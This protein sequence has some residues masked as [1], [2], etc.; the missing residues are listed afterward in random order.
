MIDFVD[1]M[2]EQLVTDRMG[3][4]ATVSFE[5]PD[6]HW[7]TTAR[8]ADKD[9]LNVYLAD[10]RENR[11]LRT[12]ERVRTAVDGVVTDEPAPRRV[13]CHYLASAWS[14]A[15]PGPTGSPARFEHALLHRF[16]S[17]LAN[18]DPF[19]ASQIYGSTPFQPSFPAVLVDAA[20][21]VTLLPVEG[22][23][24]LAELWGTMGDG[25]PV[26]PVVYFVVTVPLTLD[27]LPAGPIVTTR[28]ARFRFQ[29]D[30][31]PGEVL[32]E[33][34]GAVLDRSL[35]ASPGDP[36]PPVPG[37]WV[38]LLD[39]GGRRVQLTQAGASGRFT[40]SNLPAGSYQLRASV[41]SAVVPK[42]LPISIPAAD[43]HYDLVF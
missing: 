12:N 26:K 31:A 33:I 41:P 18:T 38:D 16:A 40:F 3:A 34:G 5:A 8:P 37:T 23:V 28:E 22:F 21:P 10:L 1:L 30:P 14:R 2:L 24:K 36:P 13:D 39:A 11:K 9:T 32:F 20:L 25:Q 43:G 27:V 42:T 15:K 17:V 29:G 4:V 19:V 35:A 7:R 6:N